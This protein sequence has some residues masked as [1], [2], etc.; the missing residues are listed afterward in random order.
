MDRRLMVFLLFAVILVL[1]FGEG[2]ARP[3]AMLVHHTLLLAAAGL[4]WR[5]PVPSGTAPYRRTMT[6]ALVLVGVGALSSIGSGYPYAS[7][8][9][10]W[11]LAMAV[12]AFHLAARGEWTDRERGALSDALLASASIQSALVLAAANAGDLGSVLA[13]YGLLNSN[14]EAAYL[15][16]GAFAAFPRLLAPGGGRARA[17]RIAGVTLCLA[18]EAVL[19]SRGALLGLA[20][21]GAAILFARAFAL[22][23]RSRLAAAAAFLLAGLATVAA[24][25]ARFAA[26]ADPY[27]YERVRI[28][29]ADLACF[30][31]HPLRG[32]GPGIFRHV[33]RRYNFPIE[34]PVRFGR[35]FETP[36]SDALG[37]L[38]E[39]GVFGLIAGAGLAIASIGY[40]ARR[41]GDPFAAG[42]LAALSAL[43]AHGL[44]EDL[45]HRP[46][47]LITAA[48]LLG[49]TLGSG[50]TAAPLPAE[51]GGAAAAR[52]LLV[53]SPVAAGWAVGVLLPFLAF[54][55]DSAMRRAPDL[56]EMERRF[57]RALRW[58][59]HQADTY[60]FP[61]TAFLAA[62]PPVPLNLDLY[63]RFRRDLDAGSRRNRHSPEF[64]LT[65]ARIEARALAEILPDTAT[66]DRAERDY[67]HAARL[68]PRDPRIRLEL[69]GFLAGLG[70]RGGARAE[71]DRALALEPEFLSAR[72]MRARLIYEEGDRDRA[73]VEWKRAAE[74]RDSFAT[75]RIES[76]YSRDILRDSPDLSRWLEA[77]LGPP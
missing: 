55:E 68:A 15:L 37:L 64:P 50:R 76:G 32:V 21:G 1:P 69:A 17:A 39:T 67:R 40:L 44:V 8:L 57:A 49:A 24:V 48:L 46:A 75:S 47:I 2:G 73:R 6:L 53:S 18:A 63:A 28:W 41:R 4:A 58:N 56:A 29:K 23:R 5:R 20:A 25:T 11:D 16:L 77:R 22:P 61:A 72:L 65:R 31:D 19:A 42:A 45:S 12:L 66:R 34:Q 36:H 51:G 74:I 35:S 62:R 3:G 14:H 33:A 7:F 54:A 30:A 26:G 9:R 10:V 60:R 27:R 59:P 38:A 52:L 70:E 13:R 71:V 43:A